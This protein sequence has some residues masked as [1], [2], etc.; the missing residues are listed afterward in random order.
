M[1][2]HVH[3]AASW[4]CAAIPLVSQCATCF[5]VQ[6][7][8]VDGYLCSVQGHVLSAVWLLRHPPTPILASLPAHAART[9]L[10]SM[11]Q[12]SER[13]FNWHVACGRGCAGGAVAKLCALR[14]LRELPEWPTPPALR[15]YCFATPAVGN[16]ALAE[17]VAS[18]GWA[19]F[20]KTYYLPGAAAVAFNC[21]VWIM[22]QQQLRA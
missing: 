8:M 21:L 16:A 11:L 2:W 19:S 3:Q 5:D 17:L 10:P 20:F 7:P 22:L 13:S 9:W 14:L 18:A 6:L 4:C 15:C 12:I 1:S